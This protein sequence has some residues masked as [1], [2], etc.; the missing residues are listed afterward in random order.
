MRLSLFDLHLDQ[1][2]GLPRHARRPRAEEGDI[3]NIDVTFID[4][5]YGDSAAYAI[6]PIAARPSG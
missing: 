2:C 6:S 1:S 4:G 5:W 3:V